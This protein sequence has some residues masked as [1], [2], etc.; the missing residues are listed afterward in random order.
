GRALAYES[1]EQR[2]SFPRPG[3]C[4]QDP[5]EILRLSL[6]VYSRLLE[7]TGLHPADLS[8]IG[9]DHQGESC[10]VWDKVTGRPVYPIIT[11]QD[12]R[13]AAVSD[14]FG[15]EHGDRIRTLTG[16]RS[17]SY[18]SA[19][20]I[21]WI[22][23]NIPQGQKR[24]EAGELLA[25][26]IN[27]WLYWNYSGRR[28][29]VTDESSSDVMM[30]CD[31]RTTG[32]N[33]WLLEKMDIPRVMLPEIVPCNSVLAVTDPALFGAEIPITCSL[34][35]CSAGIVASGA[36]AEGDLTVT[37]G[38]GSFLHLITGDR[39]IV[40]SEGLTAACSFA[41]KERKAYQLNG[42]CYTAGSAVK[43]LK[44]GLGLISDASE[45]QALAESVKDSG[46]VYFVP[47]INGVATPYWDQSARGAFLGLTAAST[48]AHLVRAVLESCAL[49]VANCSRIMKKVSGTRISRINAMGGMTV[50]SFLMQ[51][52]ADLCGMEVS[53]PAQTEPCY[54]AACMAFTGVDGSFRIEDLRKL[55]P[56]VRIYH[57]R[58]S[59][60]E[61]A[62]R[63]DN[64]T[65][66]VKRT[67]NWLPNG[68]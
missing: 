48:K 36:V 11:W 63:I 66:A 15:A 23:D 18:Y 26:T 61:S 57:P 16:L 31:P 43:W 8:C 35:D 68:V 3:W 59:A 45:T 42:I 46:G 64:W 10:L 7:K 58:M 49:Q 52:E 37:Y 14:A 25:G 34:A 29:F 19:W 2:Q 21:R 1:A 33:A 44:N 17:D 4:E 38:T 62:R 9:L 28:A 47:A 30:L 6:E 50:N 32:W 51:L 40:P 60:E 20:K 24:A 12:R 41:M 27:T 67:L 5:D 54:G 22:L 53:L 13:M 39:F 65:E 55:N 56:P